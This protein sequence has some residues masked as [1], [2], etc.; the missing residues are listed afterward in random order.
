MSDTSGL[1]AIFRPKSIAIVGA[2]RTKG[3]IGRN[4][5]HN[6]IEYEFNGPVFPINPKANVIHSIKCYP[7]VDSVP[8]EVD[9][10]IIVVP[11][12]LAPEALEQ[13]GKKG[14]KGIILITAGFKELGG[15]I[16]MTTHHHQ[17]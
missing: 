16:F 11:K 6:L 2:S 13:C 15:I 14:I 4:I 7:T 12:E 3:S 1:D 10:A 8:D 17:Y 9:L 5:L